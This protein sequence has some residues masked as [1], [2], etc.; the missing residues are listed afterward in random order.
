MSDYDPE[1]SACRDPYC[2]GCEMD[3]P[4]RP[5]HVADYNNVEPSEES[6]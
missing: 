6:L 5:E 2:P 4:A 3:F 1:T